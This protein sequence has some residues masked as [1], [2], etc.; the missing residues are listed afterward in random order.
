MTILGERNQRT[1][2]V[3]KNPMHENGLCKQHHEEHKKVQKGLAWIMSR[4]RPLPPIT[5]ARIR[6]VVIGGR[7]IWFALTYNTYLGV[8]RIKRVN[9]RG[10]K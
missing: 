4:E 9:V 6:R 2:S 3:C 10:I 8:I 1:C 7:S 5:N